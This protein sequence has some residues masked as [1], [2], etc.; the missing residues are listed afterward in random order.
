VGC[1]SLE[2]H[3]RADGRRLQASSASFDC[4]ET[5]AQA[6]IVATDAYCLMAITTV[7]LV[8]D[9]DAAGGGTCCD[10]AGDGVSEVGGAGVSVVSGLRSRVTFASAAVSSA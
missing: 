5:T 7:T 8:Y 6:F 1:S 10:G 2:V 9:I 4:A 3:D